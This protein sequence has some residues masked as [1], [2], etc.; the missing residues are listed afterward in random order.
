MNVM[1]VTLFFFL[2]FFCLCNK[3]KDRRPSPV[4]L[5]ISISFAGFSSVLWYCCISTRIV[6]VTWI[7]FPRTLSFLISLLKVQYTG[8]YVWK[9]WSTEITCRK[10]H[11]GLCI[12]P[13]FISSDEWIFV[14]FLSLVALLKNY[15]DSL[16]KIKI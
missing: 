8:I 14:L 9:A 15:I 5:I 16:K 7:T 13:D 1:C 12:F 2:F 3:I 6:T 4:A 10:R 11:S